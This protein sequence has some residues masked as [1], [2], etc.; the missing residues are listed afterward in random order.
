[1][2]LVPKYW[3][4][5]EFTLSQKLSKSQLD[6]ICGHLVITHF[7]KGEQIQLNSGDRDNVYFLK[8][9]AVKIVT[10]YDSGEEGIKH[11]VKQGDIFGLLNVIESETANDSAV[12]II[13]STICMIS[14]STLRQ[15]MK[16]NTNLNN[17]LF[18]LAGLRIQKL[19]R[20]LEDLI[21]KD[22][23]TRIREFITGYIKDFG[24]RS[25]EKLVA[26]NMLSNRDIGKLTCT[27]RQT[28]NKVLNKLKLEGYL[29]FDKN[30]M[31][32]EHKNLSKS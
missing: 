8:R 22:A 4:L 7:R 3:Y 25:G 16:G 29:H 24:E 14:S 30:E 5:A 6:H 23:E 19:E 11:L 17:H 26:K 21:Y 31:L 1:M 18:K 13:D 12:A 10:D 20:R 27:S 9:G 32:M 28:V 15:M 2:T